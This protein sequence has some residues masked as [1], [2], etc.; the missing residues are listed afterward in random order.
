MDTYNII[1]VYYYFK[2]SP[3]IIHSSVALVFRI[4]KNDNK[5]KIFLIIFNKIH[6]HI[7]Q[8]LPLHTYKYIYNILE[9]RDKDRYRFLSI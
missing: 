9:S 5:I 8:Q 3:S 6:D 7:M 2:L 4:L 1:I